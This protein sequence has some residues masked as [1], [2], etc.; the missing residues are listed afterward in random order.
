MTLPT[1]TTSNIIAD[2]LVCGAA[3][4]LIGVAA[5]ARWNR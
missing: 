3:V 5:W 2:I 1:L 4:F